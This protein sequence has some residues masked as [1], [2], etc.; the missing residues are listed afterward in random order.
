VLCVSLAGVCG[1][2]EDPHMSMN[3]KT[4]T[5][6]LSRTCINAVAHTHFSTVL[7]DEQCFKKVVCIESSEGTAQW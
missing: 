4:D 7:L 2:K 1:L 3:N 6:C 5:G